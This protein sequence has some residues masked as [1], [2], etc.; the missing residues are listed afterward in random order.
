MTTKE[1]QTLA[2]VLAALHS[3]EARIRGL[4]DDPDDIFSAAV[5]II[6]QLTGPVK[7]H[8][9]ANHDAHKL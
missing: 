3:A 1:K 9:K 6:N 8:R 7:A 5:L 4:S 2:E